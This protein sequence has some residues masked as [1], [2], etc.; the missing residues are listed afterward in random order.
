MKTNANKKRSSMETDFKSENKKQKITITLP[1]SMRASPSLRRRDNATNNL[2]NGQIA[3]VPGNN[4]KINKN[5]YEKQDKNKSIN[6]VDKPTQGIAEQI[7]KEWNKNQDHYAHVQIIAKL[8]KAGMKAEEF[9]K[10]FFLI[11]QNQANP[12]VDK[13][14]SS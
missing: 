8:F 14:P 1:E 12:S 6:Q 3:A 13:A 11:G 9:D 10:L 5:D 4:D 2:N 7:A